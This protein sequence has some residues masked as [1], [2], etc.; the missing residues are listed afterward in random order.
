MPKNRC[1]TFNNEWITPDP[2]YKKLMKNASSRDRAVLGRLAAEMT[3]QSVAAS[4]LTI[5]HIDQFAASAKAAGLATTFLTRDACLAS[6][7]RVSANDPNAAA[8]LPPLPGPLCRTV[9]RRAQADGLEPGVQEDF[10][11]L[12]ETCFPDSSPANI[13]G[14]KLRMLRAIGVAEKAGNSRLKQ[15]KD[16]CDPLVIR[17]LRAAN[18]G[19]RGAWPLNR[20]AVALEKRVLHILLAYAQKVLEDEAISDFLYRAI[21]GGPKATNLIADNTLAELRKFPRSADYLATIKAACIAILEQFFGSEHKTRKQML[22]AGAALIGLLA[23]ATNYRA[24]ALRCSRFEGPDTPVPGRLQPRKSIVFDL[25][26][27]IV[28]D[29]ER[30]LQS[31]TTLIDGYWA[32]A[33]E[34]LGAPPVEVYASYPGEKRSMKALALALGDIGKEIGVRLTPG[35]LFLH[36]LRDLAQS[37]GYTPQEIA[38]IYGARQFGNYLNHYGVFHEEVLR[39]DA[40]A[41]IIKRLLPANDN[42]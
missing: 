31:A 14:I 42:G 6:L 10:D 11:E 13:R 19:F 23:I 32:A 21:K 17:Q 16:L 30:D 38:K 41:L 3:A 27:E 7:Q 29:I 8:I 34:V 26:A 5:Q 33:R 2:T 25:R 20:Q 35:L 22:K 15:L 4:D 12:L 37:R 1:K 40:D 9:N 18:Y 39:E 28:T 36:G 24:S